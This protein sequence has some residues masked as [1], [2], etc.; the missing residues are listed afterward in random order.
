MQR[1][2]IEEI[3]NHSWFKENYVP[4]SV[5]GA[6]E[7]PDLGDV[8]SVFDNSEVMRPSLAFLMPKT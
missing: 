2:R 4:V 5:S 1:I 8:E 7:T 3:R 6:E